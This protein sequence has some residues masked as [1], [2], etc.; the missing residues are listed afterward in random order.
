MLLYLEDYSII[1]IKDYLIQLLFV[2]TYMLLM[3]KNT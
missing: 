3:E 2:R 1:R